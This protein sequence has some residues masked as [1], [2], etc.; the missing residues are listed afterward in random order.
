MSF[1][2]DEKD[3]ISFIKDIGDIEAKSTA[4]KKF[5]NF[6]KCLYAVS[7]G[8]FNPDFYMV[9]FRELG[10][11]EELF[12]VHEL[13]FKYLTE[14]GYLSLEKFHEKDSVG[15]D[16]PTQDGVLAESKFSKF[17]WNIPHKIFPFVCAYA[18][19]SS[20]SSD[21]RAG[22]TVNILKDKLKSYYEAAYKLWNEQHKGTEELSDETLSDY[23]NLAS[24]TLGLSYFSTLE[25]ILKKYGR[26][27][28]EKALLRNSLIGLTLLLMDCPNN[29]SAIQHAILRLLSDYKEHIT[30][31]VGNDPK[32]INSLYT[33]YSPMPLSSN[34]AIVTESMEELN[35]KI[36][37]ILNYIKS[38]LSAHHDDSAK[39]KIAITKDVLG[40]FESECYRRIDELRQLC[41]NAINN[42]KDKFCEEYKQAE[43]SPSGLAAGEAY[44]QDYLISFTTAT[45]KYYSKNIIDDLDLFITNVYYASTHDHYVAKKADKDFSDLEHSIQLDRK[46]YMNTICTN[47][48][49]TA[50]AMFAEVPAYIDQIGYPQYYYYEK[51][52][53][54]RIIGVLYTKRK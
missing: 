15:N 44:L 3:F 17:N 4:K 33:Y 22:I 27:D 39:Y 42:Y 34:M 13:M 41:D 38:Y 49:N 19:A 14:Q 37:D 46:N 50:P 8:H 25:D 9:P 52:M 51:E 29:S 18:L 11:S 26:D 47:F 32:N 5:E 30:S 16:V 43:A 48:K 12:F 2:T 23:D 31:K 1:I 35:K 21:T 7:F 45:K 53:I 28:N 40:E 20:P 54:Y 6:K 24:Y 10:V 36:D